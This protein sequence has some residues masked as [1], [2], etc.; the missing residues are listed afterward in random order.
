MHWQQGILKHLSGLVL[1]SVH[2]HADLV[3]EDI[4]VYWLQEKELYQLL[5]AISGEEWGMSTV[6][7]IWQ[8]RQWR[9][10]VP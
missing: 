3:W 2:L 5:T 4:W 6:K 7:C 8:D 9:Q 10:R 1:L